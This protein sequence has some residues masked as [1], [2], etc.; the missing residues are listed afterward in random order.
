VR[1]IVHE[2]SPNV[3]VAQVKTQAAQIDETISEERTF[4][5]LCSG[6][7]ALALGIACV[8]LYGTMAYT[9]A[10]RTSAIGIRVALGAMR[11]QIVWMVLREVLVVAALG[12]VVGLGAAWVTTRFV[13]SYLF[14]MKQH[15]P[16]VLV[17]AVLVLIAAAGVAGI[18]PAWRAARIDPLVALRHE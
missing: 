3:P 11:G 1:Q 18:G 2:A 16:G 4:A 7:A 10:R 6:F 17:G 5:Q 13:E 15:D 9:V 12:V 14:G 8:G